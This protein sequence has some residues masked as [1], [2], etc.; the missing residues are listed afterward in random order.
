MPKRPADAVPRVYEILRNKAISYEFRPGERINEIEL[1]EELDVSRTPVREALNRLISEGMMTFIPNKGF[2]R[3]PLDITEMTSLFEVRRTIEV[4]AA[5]L[6]CQRGSNASIAE[7]DAFWSAAR[8]RDLRKLPFAEVASYD[9]QFHERLVAISGNAEYVRL[10]G[11]INARIRFVRTIAL[12]HPRYSLA[13]GPKEHEAIIAALIKRDADACAA[14]LENHI[15]MGL[16]D[17]M[18]FLKEGLSRIYLGTHQLRPSA[19][20][21]TTDI[22]GDQ[23]AAKPRS[24]GIARKGK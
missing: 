10:L 19:G 18:T 8:K 12:E 23:T 11:M 13:S 15:H 14:V 21:L 9:E 17:A 22:A 16:E 3:L 5:R 24:R 7:L 2:Y 6:A 1:A 4:A 20:A